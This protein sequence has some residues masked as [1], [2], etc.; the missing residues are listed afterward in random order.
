MGWCDEYD[1]NILYN[2]PWPPKPEEFLGS[3]EIHDVFAKNTVYSNSQC[4]HWSSPFKILQSI[5][6]SQ[7]WSCL[8]MLRGLPKAIHKKTICRRL[9]S[10]QT[11]E[12]HREISQVRTGFSWVFHGFSTGWEYTGYYGLSFKLNPALNHFDQDK[13]D[14]RTPQQK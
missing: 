3:E 13:F 6:W 11:H 8:G 9:K 12:N 4:F 7:I 1:L 14:P 2:V 5:A 10:T